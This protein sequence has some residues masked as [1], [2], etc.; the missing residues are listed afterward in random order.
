MKNKEYD[1]DWW[2]K[3]CRSLW[4]ASEKDWVNRSGQDHY[5]RKY[6]VIPAIKRRLLDEDGF[7]TFI[8]LGCGDGFT[9]ELLLN[10][11]KY[12]FKSN[13]IL[14]LVDVSSEQLIIAHNRLKKNYFNISTYNNDLNN[15]IWHSKINLRSPSFFLSV[16]V[17]QEMITLK[18]G[19]E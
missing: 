5:Y 1:K 15:G 11:L 7:N 18:N 13:M 16:F 3:W 12:K 14:N 8:D 4:S 19:V 17:L 6:A 2:F 9:T 10:K